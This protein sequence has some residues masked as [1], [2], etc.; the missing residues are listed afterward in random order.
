MKAK[1]KNSVLV[2]KFVMYEFG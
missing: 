1:M 2:C